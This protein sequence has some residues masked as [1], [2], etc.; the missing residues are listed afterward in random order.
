MEPPPLHADLASLAFLLGTWSGTGHGVYP[1]IADF[2]YGEEVTFSHAGK[3]FLAYHQRTWEAG[4]AAGE[5]PL[6]T[7]MGYW[8][9]AGPGRL[10]VMIA[11][12]TGIVEIQEG[13]VAGTTVS[14]T[15][16][17]VG[18]TGTAKD[19]TT[20]ERNLTVA[21]DRLTYRLLMGAVGRPHQL[22]LEATLV[23]GP[24]VPTR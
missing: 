8:R 6:H 21:G 13:T 12:P 24:D 7:E 18:L 9:P 19:V 15:A 2:D 22:H 14:L 23:K 20:L 3:P 4:A 17:F 16:A 1:T 10:E 5:R 11:H